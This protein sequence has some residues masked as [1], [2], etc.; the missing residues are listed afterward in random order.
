MINFD[1]NSV[2]CGSCWEV[3]L[4]PVGAEVRL[5]VGGLDREA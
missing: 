1:S 2:K 3:Y 4:V 5:G